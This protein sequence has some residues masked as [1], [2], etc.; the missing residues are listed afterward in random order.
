M[1][2]NLKSTFFKNFYVFP[3]TKG[4][5]NLLKSDRSDIILVSGDTYMD[6][7]FIGIA[8]KTQNDFN[9]W[10]LRLM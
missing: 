10:I 5:I 3:T 8:V 1:E 4:E 9:D 7:P 2:K 6:N